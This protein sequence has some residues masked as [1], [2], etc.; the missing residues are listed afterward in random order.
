M[1]REVIATDA[2]ASSGST[3]TARTTATTAASS[4]HERAVKSRSTER[5]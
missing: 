3:A 1:E 2:D 5:R 4:A